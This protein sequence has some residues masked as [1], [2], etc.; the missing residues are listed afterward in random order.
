MRIAL[1]TDGIYP[2][3]IGGMQK[4]SF[5]LAK[6]LAEN[7]VMVD[8]YHT[9]SDLSAIDLKDVFTAEENKFITSIPVP[10]PP[11]GR[12]PG[13]YIREMRRYSKRLSEKL[14]SRP[15]DFIYVQGLCGI[16]LLGHSNN[17]RTPAGV[18]FHGLE[19]FQK[20]ADL[21][22]RLE[23]YLFR[24]TVKR[25][26]RN[27]D[28]VFSLGGNL[29]G[30]IRKAGIL[31]EKIIQI[32][33]GI[34]RSWINMSTPSVNKKK[35]FV[36]VGRYERR[37]G[38]EE[39]TKAITD[40]LPQHEFEFEF[41]GMIPAERKIRSGFIHYHGAISQ[42]EQIRTILASSDVLVCPSYSEGMPT[43]ILEA[44]ACGLAVIAT[45]VGAVSEQV[46]KSTGMLISPGDIGQL[47][48]AIRHFLQLPDEELK[49]MK[50]KAVK[51]IRERFLWETIMPL[52]IGKIEQYLAAKR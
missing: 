29:T 14:K 18:N 28:I 22:T 47:K 2:Y 48:N 15:A 37:K 46:D 7:K 43:V 16:H 49:S 27:A 6:Y 25:S 26:M 11:A 31:P 4:H 35:K 23:Q 33:I 44:M 52:T 3:V 19:M 9:A 51:R 13:H 10:F 12:F 50:R 39:L 36:F 24:R 45:D 5:Y 1:L 38:V 20:P 40:L 41:I 8:L 17:N 32:P 30:I 21:R 42:S 34:D